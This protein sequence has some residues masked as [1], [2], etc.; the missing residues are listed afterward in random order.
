MQILNVEH[1]TLNA[2]VVPLDIQSSGIN[3]QHSDLS[4]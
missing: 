1:G 2:E 4:T 3:I